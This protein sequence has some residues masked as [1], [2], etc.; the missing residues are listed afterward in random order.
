MKK[1]NIISFF[2]KVI[3]F[4]ILFIKKVLNDDILALAAQL[5]YYLILSFIP[6]LMFLM[7]LVGFINLNSDEI[8][9]LLSTVMPRASFELIESTVIQIIDVQQ[10][11]IL[12]I[13]IVLAIW[14]SSSG[15]SA[16]IKG[17][18]KAYGVKETRSY[19][20]LK[21]A[22]IG[23]TLMLAITI[24]A[25]LFLF[26]FGDLITELIIS[27]IANSTIIIFLWNIIRYLVVVCIMVCVFAFLYNVTPCKRLGWGEVL[28][29]AALTTLGWILT[30]Y[31]FAFYVN[32]FSNYS[33]LY[34]G[35]GA[36]FILM[37]WLFIS[38]IILLLGGEVNAVLANY[39]I[40][41]N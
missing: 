24:I 4:I 14:V 13:S 18:N 25:T 20:R 39:G 29:G 9:N 10:K 1:N 19:I 28:P 35:L 31:L 8:I 27:A 37:T 5:A 21:I 36:V 16:V 30:S 41:S 33:R 2:K 40:E 22:S 23:Y 12:W 34:G 7:T 11:G 6:F 3:I 38:S 32:N 17:L 26:V 15:F